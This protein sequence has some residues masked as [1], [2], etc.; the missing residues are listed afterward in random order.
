M[1]I[2]IYGAGQIM[3]AAGVSADP[4]NLAGVSGSLF[5][6]EEGLLG[7]IRD[8]FILLGSHYERL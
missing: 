5:G 6:A 8:K 1:H 4:E 7:R 2:A 3:D